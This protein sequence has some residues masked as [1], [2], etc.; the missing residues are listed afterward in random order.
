MLTVQ[1]I[2]K[3]NQKT[4]KST[5]D[6]IA[7]L[8]PKVLV[9]D[10]GS[11]DSTIDICKKYNIEIFDVSTKT[12]DQARMFLNSKSQNNWNLWIEPWETIIQNNFN[13]D[14][15]K[16]QFGYVRVIH[17]QSLLWDIRLWRGHCKFVNPVFERIESSVG[18][19]TGIVLSS[20]GGHNNNDA[21]DCLQKWKLE[22]PLS[23]QPYYYQAC[24]LLAEKRYEEF[25]SCAE[26][27]LFLEKQP[28]VSAIMTRYYYAMTQLMHKRAVKPTLQNLNLCLC[29]KPLMA[30]F[31]CLTGDVYYHL[32]NK[33]AV[34]KE[35]YENAIIL[36]AKRLAN[37]RWPMDIS[38]YNKYPKMM[39]KSCDQLLNNNTNYVPKNSQ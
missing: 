3:N 14:K 12:R 30:E 5:L 27:Y 4:L 15:E 21:M 37:D 9:G 29:A 32:L 8:R 19:N 11:T 6:S 33:F 28:T 7:E 20:T 17:G 22:S 1:I 34:A 31:W 16:I 10:Y 13:F 26:N 25:L 39:I 35:F 2:T 24:L 36:G 38:K 18:T 23:A